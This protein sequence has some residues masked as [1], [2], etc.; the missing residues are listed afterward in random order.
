MP[1]GQVLLSLVKCDRLHLGTIEQPCQSLSLARWPSL[2]DWSNVFGRND[3]SLSQNELTMVGNTL[4]LFTI[5]FVLTLYSCQCHIVVEN[6]KDSWLCLIFHMFG[7]DMLPG[8]CFHTFTYRGFGA[9]W[10]KST[11]IWHSLPTMDLKIG[12]NNDLRR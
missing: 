12:F 6:P 7:F 3:L 5:A 1:I 2:R 11:T 9:V 10:I 8:M 4:V